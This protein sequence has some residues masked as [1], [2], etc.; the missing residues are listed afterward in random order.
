MSSVSRTL[1]CEPP[2]TKSRKARHRRAPP[3]RRQCNGRR[4]ALLVLHP[5]GAAS[6]DRFKEAPERA[7]WRPS[8]FPSSLTTELSPL[9]RTWPCSYASAQCR[10]RPSVASSLKCERATETSTRASPAG[11]RSILGPGTST[12]QMG[13]SPPRAR[14]L[15]LDH[16]LQPPQGGHLVLKPPHGAGDECL[17]LG[18]GHE[19]IQ[20]RP[21][22]GSSLGHVSGWI[23]AARRGARRSTAPPPGPGWPWTTSSIWIGGSAAATSTTGTPTTSAGCCPCGE[24]SWAPT[25]A[26]R[27]A[28]SRTSPPKDRPCS[29][30]TIR[31]DPIADTFVFA[32]EFYER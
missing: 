32:G 28:D 2:P 19:A 14:K 9:T 7:R 30:A 20:S 23:S 3:P 31:A 29:W 10:S 15:Q 22:R 24:P 18:C 4:A 17:G 25:S 16:E 6:A 5:D 13:A 1:V 12:R 27:C 26:A 8:T 21:D 11:S